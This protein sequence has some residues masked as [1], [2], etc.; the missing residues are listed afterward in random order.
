ML[1]VGIIQVLGNLMYKKI[2]IIYNLRRSKKMKKILS[3]L[4]V[5]ILVFSMVGCGNKSDVKTEETN[6]GMGTNTDNSGK[7][8][9]YNSGNIYYM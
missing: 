2:K 3:V 8:R 9:N 4:L 5:L 1:L 7:K 6:N